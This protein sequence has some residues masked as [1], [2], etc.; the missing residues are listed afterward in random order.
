MPQTPLRVPH[1]GRYVSPAALSLFGSQWPRISMLMGFRG[2]LPFD[3]PVA[4]LS[5]AARAKAALRWLEWARCSGRQGP[6]KPKGGLAGRIDG[7]HLTPFW[8]C[9]WRGQW[10][11]AGKAAVTRAWGR[12]GVVTASLPTPASA[13]SCHTIVPDRLNLEPRQPIAWNR[14]STPS[15]S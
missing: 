9:L 8:L 11:R 1:A 13:R 14:T 5:R 2:K 4:H 6:G 3:A 15:E 12:S 7:A 10:T